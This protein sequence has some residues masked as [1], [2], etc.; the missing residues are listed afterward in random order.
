[1]VSSHVVFRRRMYVMQVWIFLVV[2]RCQKKK[3]CI[4]IKKNVLI[5]LFE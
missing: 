4:K 3:S 5:S 1:M 2:F